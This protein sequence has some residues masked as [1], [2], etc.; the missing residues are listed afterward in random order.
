M[1]QA[2]C[3]KG[4][5]EA[6]PQYELLDFSRGAGTMDPST[7]VVRTTQEVV[8]FQLI[9]VVLGSKRLRFASASNNM[10]YPH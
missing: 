6:H 1:R 5:N 9:S 4:C 10:A 7:A 2:H 8:V 3:D